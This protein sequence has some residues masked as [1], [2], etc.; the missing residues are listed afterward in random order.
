[1]CIS[2]HICFFFL[3]SYLDILPCKLQDSSSVMSPLLSSS[4]FEP[5]LTPLVQEMFLVAQNSDNHQLQQFASWALALLRHHLWSKELLGVDGDRNV[6]ETNSKPVSQSFPEDSVV[7]KLSLWLMDLK[8][9]EVNFL[10]I[11]CV[12]YFNEVLNL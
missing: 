7:L 10:P 1:M 9:T 5:Y 4:V 11:F 12:N 3:V 2:L 6:A 8:Y